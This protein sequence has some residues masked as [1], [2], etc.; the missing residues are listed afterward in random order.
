MY[1]EAFLVCRGGHGYFRS[2][3]APSTHPRCL[4]RRLPT[5]V[6]TH[7]GEAPGTLLGSWASAYHEVGQTNTV[8][9]RF[10]STISS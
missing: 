9:G 6:G 2:V 3:H 1:G 10:L 4:N 8:L 7:N 5:Y